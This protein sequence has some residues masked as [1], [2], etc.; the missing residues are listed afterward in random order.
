MQVRGQKG[1]SSAASHKH[2][3]RFVKYSLSESEILFASSLLTIHLYAFETGRTSVLFIVIGRNLHNV[4]YV[5]FY[6]LLISESSYDCG[7]C[8]ISA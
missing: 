2:V 6:S 5:R 4:L 7:C 1:V 8:I 3:E